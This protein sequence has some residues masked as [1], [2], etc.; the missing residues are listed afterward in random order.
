M[1]HRSQKLQVIPVSN[2]EV[3]LL[4]E[5]QHEAYTISINALSLLDEEDPTILSY[6]ATETGSEVTKFP[7]N[8]V[9][10]FD[11]YPQP[12]KR[13]RITYIPDNKYNVT[14]EGEIVKLSD[15]RYEQALVAARL[16][17]VEDHPDG[18]SSI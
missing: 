1:Y 14:R 8:H 12:R 18:M 7:H 17:F 9:I 10:G 16:K 15:I 3:P 13:R 6:V 2:K 4:M 11:V 5:E